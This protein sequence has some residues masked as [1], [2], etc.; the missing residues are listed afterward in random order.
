M[1]TPT[2]RKIRVL[3]AGTWMA[4]SRGTSTLHYAADRKAVCGVSLGTGRLTDF[5]LHIC[6]KCIAYVNSCAGSPS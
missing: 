4:R 5:G 2:K 1:S 3:P 6:A